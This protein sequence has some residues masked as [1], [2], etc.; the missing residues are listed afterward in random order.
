MI[1][2]L[3]SVSQCF[4]NYFIMYTFLVGVFPKRHKK[5][6]VDLLILGIAACL[7]AYV[8]SLK[9]PLLNTAAVAAIIVPALFAIFAAKP[10]KIIIAG[11]S[12]VGISVGSE[13]LSVTFLSEISHSTIAAAA[14]ASVQSVE[15][16]FISSGIFFLATFPAKLLLV[17]F[18]KLSISENGRPNIA[19]MPL[20]ILSVLIA[21]FIVEVSSLPQF[22]QSLT[23][24]GALITIGLLAINIIVFVLDS[25]TR[26]KHEYQMELA[27]MR[28]QGE[29]KEALI[30]Q[31][32]ASFNEMNSIVH[33]FKHQL[34]TL[35]MMVGQLSVEDEQQRL[36]LNISQALEGLPHVALYQAVSCKVLRCI[37]IH[38]HNQCE[39]MGVEFVTQIAFSDFDYM[40]CQDICAIFSNALDNALF[41]C[42]QVQREGLAANIT[43][44]IQPM[45]RMV[46]IRIT[47][48]KVNPIEA[49]DGIIQTTKFDKKRH[50]IG[51]LNIKRAVQKYDGTVTVE[52]MDTTFSLKMFF[53][54]FS[55][56][57]AEK[58]KISTK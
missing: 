40:S 28:A 43:L 19:L 47:N 50:G 12:L 51:L 42:E 46:F 13:L 39:R 25:D 45:N 6:W 16:S 10:S 26:K 52:Y 8:N 35:Q 56:A 20:P 34:L 18:G 21:Y 49:H 17:R 29:M 15:F 41:A 23:T 36:L 30:L 54:N 7:L 57:P 22:S 53:P 55:E 1:V 31:Q 37:L 14:E 38:T 32:D 5:P 58:T 24:Q 48:S 33:D 44:T 11:L 4:V 3:L 27:E 2:R 9:Q